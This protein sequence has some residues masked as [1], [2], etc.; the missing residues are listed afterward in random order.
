MPEQEQFLWGG[1]VFGPDHQR[2]LGTLHRLQGDRISTLTVGQLDGQIR[3]MRELVGQQ[4]AHQ[5]RV[6]I[7][8]V[9]MHLSR[10][11]LVDPSRDVLLVEPVEMDDDRRG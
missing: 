10:H 8:L 2:T 6:G 4:P 9:G 1:S 3:P 11:R 7:H 5:R